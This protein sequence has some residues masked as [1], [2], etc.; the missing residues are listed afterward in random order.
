ME[1]SDDLRTR[2]Q[3]ADQLEGGQAFIPV[4]DL[5]EEVEFDELGLRPAGLP[6][7][8]YEQFFHLRVAQFDILDFC[9]NPDYE[10][11]AWPEEYWP[12]DFAPET[13][14]D[15]EALKKSFFDER[16]EFIEYLLDQS[17][18]LYKPIPHGDGQTLLREAM[19]ILEHSAYHIGQLAIITRLLQQ[20][21]DSL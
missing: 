2:N 14:E 10:A 4:E 9:R 13:E 5:V 20:E 16:Q 11:P 21:D 7:S 8:F 18:P 12:V 19:L 15:W 17:N 3:L 1:N 6:Y